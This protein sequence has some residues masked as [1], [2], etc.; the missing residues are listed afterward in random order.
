MFPG[1]LPP[2]TWSFVTCSLYYWLHIQRGQYYRLDSQGYETKSHQPHPHRHRRC[3]FPKHV[4]V[5]SIL[6]TLLFA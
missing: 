5:H 3:R 1:R 2:G 6:H 4:G